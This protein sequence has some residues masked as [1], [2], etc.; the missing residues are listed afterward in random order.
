MIVLTVSHV[1]KAFGTEQ[2]LRDISLTLAQRE[3]LGLVGVNGSGKTTLLKI[4]AGQLHADEGA[5]AMQKSMVV[6]YLAQSYQPDEGSTVL[7]EMEAVFAPVYAMEN[8]LRDIETLMAGAGDAALKSLSDEYA[9]LHELFERADG[10]S[11]HSRVQGVLSGLGFSKTQQDQQASLLSGGELTR[12]TLGRLLLQKP[13]LLL[14]DEPTNHLDLEALQWLEDFLNDYPGAVLLVS[15]DRYFL[16]RVCTGMTEIL[17]GVSEQYRGN[18]TQY[19]AQR[20]ERF[21]SRSRAYVAQ[22]KEI[23]RQ[24]AIIARFRSFN[25]EKSIRAAESR[26]K[27][28]ERMTLLDKPMEERQ[29]RFA[30][31]ARGRVGFEA[32]KLEGLA[33]AYGPR[34]LFSDVGLVLHAGDRAALIGANGIGKST[35]LE[36]L[37]GG[38]K[39]DSGSFRFGTNADVGYYDQKQQNLHEEKTVLREVWDDFPRLLQHEVRGALGLFLFSGDEVFKP[40]SALSGGEKARVAL[41]KLML[42]HNNFLVLDEPTNHLDSDSR[43][44]LEGALEGFEG[45]ILA[46]SHDRYFINRF[47]SKILV[48]TDG[49]LEQFEGNYDAYLREQERRR[50]P[51]YEAGQGRNKT[52]ASKARKRARAEQERLDALGAQALAAEGAVA[53]AEEAL[54]ALGDSL[55]DPAVYSVP[56]AAGKAASEIRLKK[57]ELEGLYAAWETAEAALQAFEESE[58]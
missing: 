36:V 19:M 24:Q 51:N 38:L 58:S 29:V 3:R 10:Y 18:Y 26:E 1:K 14:L 6:G 15:H 52:E 43:E 16:D 28:L 55:M 48:M 39:A 9:R 56:E 27:A 33:K 8:R 35:L 41:T 25:R 42:R 5:I 11:C 57:A 44:V 30:F 49:G 37:T 17:F 40:V 50:N 13:D 46:V 53:R 45:T 21:T 7:S 22:Q 32:L 54:A 23:E 47:A 31:T 12:L 4:L 20:E 2:V 34:R